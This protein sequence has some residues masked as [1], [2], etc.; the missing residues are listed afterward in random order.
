MLSA[1]GTYRLTEARLAQGMRCKAI[2]GPTLA[3]LPS[4]THPLSGSVEGPLALT[5]LPLLTASVAPEVTPGLH[6]HPL[7]LLAGSLLPVLLFAVVL[8]VGAVSGRA[9]GHARR[10]VQPP[11]GERSVRTLTLVPAGW[12]MSRP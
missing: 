6:G 2:C 4:L 1:R 3:P 10:L 12:I 5:T 11:I 9:S 8:H 7:G